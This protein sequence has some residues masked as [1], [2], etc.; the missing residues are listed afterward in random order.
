MQDWLDRT[1][2]EYVVANDMLDFLVAF[3][4]GGWDLLDVGGSSSQQC[5]SSRNVNSGGSSSD[6]QHSSVR[7]L[8][9]GDGHG[10]GTVAVE[11]GQPKVHF[12]L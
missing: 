10:I 12:R 7:I 9:A 2:N 11:M 6:R 3:L 5:N 8:S 4:E 1:L